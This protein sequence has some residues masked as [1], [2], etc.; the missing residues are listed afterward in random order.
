MSPSL[1]PSIPTGLLYEQSILS[2][3]I[4]YHE[5]FIH[6][7]K[8]NFFVYS[9][10]NWSNLVWYIW[11]KVHVLLFKYACLNLISSIKAPNLW[12]PLERAQVLANVKTIEIYNVDFKLKAPN[13][14]NINIPTDIT[15]T[16]SRLKVMRNNKIINKGKI[17]ALI[18]CQILPTDYFS[19]SL[20]KEVPSQS[21]V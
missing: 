4:L 18:F 10:C 6:L 8:N 21:S 12:A 14:T 16:E 7:Q 13:V 3:L 2:D 17:N 19:C 1:D 9:H 20:Y 11:I 5:Q 15:K